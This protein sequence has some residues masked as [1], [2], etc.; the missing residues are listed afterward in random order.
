[1]RSKHLLVANWKMNYGPAKAASYCRELKGAITKLTNTDV[2]IA[3]PDLSL[4]A[5]A[6]ELNGTILSYGSQNVHWAESGAYTGETSFAFLKE[7]GATFAII[8]HS[9]R[10]TLFGE[11]DSGVIK[12]TTAAIAAGITPIVCVGETEAERVEGETEK[13]LRTQVEPLLTVLTKEASASIVLAYEPVWAIGTGRSASLEEIA[14]AHRLLT[15]LWQTK[16]GFAPAVLYGGSVNPGN[17]GP[18]LKLAEVDGALVGGASLKL[19]QWLGLVEI[20]ESTPII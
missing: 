18:I 16:F 12:R 7:L 15:D 3:P 19:D 8:G 1:M 2:W 13:V 6:A 5:A 20:A 4:P 14:D 11:T 9:E 17:F 10:R